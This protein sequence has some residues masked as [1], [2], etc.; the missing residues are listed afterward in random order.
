MQKTIAILTCKNFE[1]DRS[2]LRKICWFNKCFFADILLLADQSVLVYYKNSVGFKF[3]DKII[4][5]LVSKWFPSSSILLFNIFSSS[6]VLIDAIRASIIGSA[7][8]LWTSLYLLNFN[9]NW[10]ELYQLT[11]KSDMQSYIDILGWVKINGF[12]TRCFFRAS[13]L[14][15]M[16]PKN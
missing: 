7:S 8:K 6:C 4:S 16:Y 13:F 2:Y 11:V 12:Q 1:I 14:K 9:F 5:P 3:I 15:V 10:S